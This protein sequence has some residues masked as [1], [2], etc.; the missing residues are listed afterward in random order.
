MHRTPQLTVFIGVILL[1]IFPASSHGDPKNET[2]DYL[3]TIG[4]GF[5]YDS[6]THLWNMFLLVEPLK[7]APGSGPFYLEA[8]FENPRPNSP[9]LIVTEDSR[10][11]K[12]SCIELKTTPV[13]GMRNRKAYLVTVRV[14]ADK[15]RSQLID[16]LNQKMVYHDLG[17]PEAL[18]HGGRLPPGWHAVAPSGETW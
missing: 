11:V 1:I 15:R 14:F 2:S 4:A 16:T 7:R 9:P 6:H 8:M 18:L 10:K 5:T 13:S 12:K 3:H 17:D